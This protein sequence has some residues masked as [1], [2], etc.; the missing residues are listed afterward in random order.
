MLRAANLLKREEI[1]V[2]KF[3]TL[4]KLRIKYQYVNSVEHFYLLYV[5]SVILMTPYYVI[6]II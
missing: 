6:T 4:V 3:M 5:H 2:T 1:Q